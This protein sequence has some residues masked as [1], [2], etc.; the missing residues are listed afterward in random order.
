MIEME[1]KS[2]DEKLAEW[3]VTA[4]AMYAEWVANWQ[5]GEWKYP[6]WEPPTKN[7]VC[8]D[9]RIQRIAKAIIRIEAMDGD[10]IE[11]R[12][13]DTVFDDMALAACL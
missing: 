4:P 11:L 10:I 2:Y 7:R 3:K 1:I 12:A 5:P 13:D 6:K 9:W 8:E